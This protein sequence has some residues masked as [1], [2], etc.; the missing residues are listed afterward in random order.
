MASAMSVT[1]NSSKHSTEWLRAI[2]RATASMASLSSP[3]LTAPP[4]E[5]D[6][7]VEA[8]DDIIMT[9]P[10]GLCVLDL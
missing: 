4:D 5:V 3:A 6:A 2:S 8:A 7:E 9:M 10:D 1:W